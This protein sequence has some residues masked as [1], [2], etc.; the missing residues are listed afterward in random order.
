M[1][2][3]EQIKEKLDQI[4]KL[5]QPKREVKTSNSLCEVRA[6]DIK[7]RKPEPMD[8]KLEDN[9]FCDGWDYF[10]NSN[11][12]ICFYNRKAYLKALEEWESNN[13]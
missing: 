3:L 5:L 13:I 4:L 11:G 10:K 2:E 6:E 1:T 8:F 7:K 12:S 9:L